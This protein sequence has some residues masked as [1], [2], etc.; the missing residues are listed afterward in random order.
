M[1]FVTPSRQLPLGMTMSLPRRLDLLDWAAG[2]SWVLE[3]DYDSEFR[4]ATRPLAA[5]QALDSHGCVLYTGTFSKV[6]FPSLRLGYLVVPEP[7]IEAFTAARH[8]ADYHSPYLE[9]AVM[10]DFISEGHFERHIR[11]M[12]SVYQERQGILLDAARRELDDHLML[13]PADAGMTLI[14]WLHE[15][16]DLAVARAA[17]SAGIDLLPMSP[18]SIE[19]RIDPGVLLGYSGV[20]EPDLKEGVTR[21]AAVMAALPRTAR[22]A[23][24][25]GVRG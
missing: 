21:L 17:E 22:R 11:R 5:L 25:N 13:E 15:A 6:M 18:F 1:A 9:Q 16:D 7:L 8:F 19:R 20:R 4:Y 10:A 12:R 3:D 24:S 23:P 14:G 2:A